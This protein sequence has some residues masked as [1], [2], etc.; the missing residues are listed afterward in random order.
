MAIHNAG[1]VTV[2]HTP[3]PI[4][5]LRDLLQRPP[6]EKPYVLMPVGYPH[7]TAMVPNIGK[8][9]LSEIAVFL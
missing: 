7:E 2:T 9:S 8:K 4:K 6:N 5:I 1:L 3:A